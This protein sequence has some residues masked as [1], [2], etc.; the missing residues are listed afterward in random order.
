[1]KTISFLSFATLVFVSAVLAGP[2][3]GNRDADKKGAATTT[4]NAWDVP[5]PQSIFCMTN[6]P[7]K[8]PFFPNSVRLIPKETTNSAPVAVS[9][10]EF[11]LKGISG[12]AGQRLVLVCNRNVAKGESGDVKTA[13]GRTIHI[14]VLDIKETSAIILVDGQNEPFEIFLPKFLQ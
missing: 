7:V 12:I 1:M 4:S 3:N 8:D 14:K 5:I 9:V 13:F 2:A 10:T 6:G 11:P